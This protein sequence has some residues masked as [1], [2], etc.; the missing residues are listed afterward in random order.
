VNTVLASFSGTCP[1]CGCIVDLKA[2]HT[3]RPTDGPPSEILPDT[4]E[5]HVMCPYC[6]CDRVTLKKVEHKK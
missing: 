4:G 2:S 1:C 6:W 3:G 5:R